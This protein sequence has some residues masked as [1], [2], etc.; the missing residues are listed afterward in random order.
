MKKII[1]S[2]VINNCREALEFYKGIFGGEVKN[3]K[4]GEANEMFKG[5]EGK[6]VH[7][8]LWINSDCII[9]M[10]D[11]MRG[12]NE[13]TSNINLMLQMDSM[14]EIKRVFDGLSKGGK[15]QFE[16]QKAFWGSYHAVV[17]DQFGVIWSLDFAG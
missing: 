10:N 2:I 17:I 6:I 3:L 7:S 1:P 12:N 15:V 5:F 11:V 16:L 8:E 14:D 4:T 9:H 13:F